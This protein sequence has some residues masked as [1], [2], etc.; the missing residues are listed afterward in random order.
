MHIK[1][2]CRALALPLTQSVEKGRINRRR[3]FCVPVA[4]LHH[5]RLLLRLTWEMDEVAVHRHTNNDLRCEWTDSLQKRMKIILSASASE[6]KCEIELR[7][8][9]EK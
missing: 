1:E 5:P 3:Y 7:R 8:K 4:R 9:K 2:V 6:M